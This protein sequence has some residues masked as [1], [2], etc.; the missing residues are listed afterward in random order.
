MKTNEIGDTS[1]QIDTAI[2]NKLIEMMQL[3]KEN[4]R[5]NTEWGTKSPMGLARTVRRILA[6]GGAK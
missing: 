4:G 5:V 2:G 1:D 6:E 3:K